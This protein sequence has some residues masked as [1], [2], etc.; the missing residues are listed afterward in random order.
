MKLRPS[1]SAVAANATQMVNRLRSH[2]WRVARGATPSTGEC[3]VGRTSTICSITDTR[4]PSVSLALD[5]SAI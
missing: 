1:P 5:W 2:E 4:A 3:V